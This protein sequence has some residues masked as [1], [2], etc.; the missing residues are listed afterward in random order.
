MVCSLREKEVDSHYNTGDGQ[1]NTERASIRQRPSTDDPAYR[2]NGAG[3][4]VPYNSAADGASTRNDEE[5]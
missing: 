4:H 1:Y 5:L 2:D 3:L